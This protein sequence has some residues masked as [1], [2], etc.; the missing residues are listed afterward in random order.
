MENKDAALSGDIS[1]LTVEYSAHQAILKSLKDYLKGKIL[2][3]TTARV[4]FRDPIPPDP[5]SAGR[6]A[7]NILGDETPVVAAFQNIPAH[8]LRKKLNQTLDGDVL[9]CAD[10]PEAAEQVIHLAQRG[11]MRAYYAGN[12]DNAIVV[13]GLTALLISMNRHYHVK[14]ASIGISGLSNEKIA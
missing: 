6:L 12:L 13:E 1:V 8:T 3:D 5:P 11:G 10:D 9:I 4:D 2:V 7:Q 14:T